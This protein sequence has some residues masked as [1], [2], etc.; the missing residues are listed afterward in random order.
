MVLPRSR[1]Q[2]EWGTGQQTSVE[3]NYLDQM[4]EELECHTGLKGTGGKARTRT[5]VS[6]TTALVFAV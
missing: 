2:H 1:L 6:L 5:L 3:L 4:L